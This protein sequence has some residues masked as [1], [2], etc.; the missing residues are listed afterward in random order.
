MVHRNTLGLGIRVFSW[1]RMGSAG[2]SEGFEGSGGVEVCGVWV[3]GLR[4][5][6]NIRS[7]HEEC[8]ILSLTPL[9]P[10]KI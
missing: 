1:I 9:A 7:L 8:F 4:V 6:V 5:Q 10:K 2:A 3:Y